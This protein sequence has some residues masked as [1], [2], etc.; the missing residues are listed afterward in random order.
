[1][2]LW[3]TDPLNFDAPA[4]AVVRHIPDSFPRCIQHT[5]A[6]IDVVLARRQHATYISALKEAGVAVRELPALENHPDCCFVEDPV[7]VLGRRAL[8]NRSAA[9]PRQGEGDSLRTVLAEWCQLSFMPAP[10]TLDGGDVLRIGRQLYV[11]QTTRS[12]PDGISW[13]QLAA[14]AEGLTVVPVPLRK[15]L[16]LKSSATL[17]GPELL[18]YRRG[19]LNPRAFSG[20]EALATDEVHGANVLALGD[21]VLVSAAA[22]RTAEE[23][24]RRG[25]RVR[26]VPLSELHKADGA[27]TCLSIR[28]P[29]AGA[30]VV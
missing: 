4:L 30:W 13:L 25:L 3:S 15:G 20:V 16:H 11:G 26:M 19:T 23:L 28:L 7:L 2:G 22:P 17:A 6:P 9:P 21:T 27:L 18:V 1:M 8:L 12:N 24:A 29:R 5:P 14:T 10:G